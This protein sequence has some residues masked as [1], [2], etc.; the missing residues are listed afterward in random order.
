MPSSEWWVV[1][2]RKAAR[3]R[4][5][6]GQRA[7]SAA[8]WQRVAAGWGG[9]EGGGVG[10]WQH[11][12]TDAGGDHICG[13]SGGPGREVL[14]SGMSNKFIF[15]YRFWHLLTVFWPT[16]TQPKPDAQA[17]ISGHPTFKMFLFTRSIVLKGRF[18]KIQI[19]IKLEPYTEKTFVWAVR[20]WIGL[21][22]LHHN[23]RFYSCRLVQVL[24]FMKL[25]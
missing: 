16:L 1:A 13:G 4:V 5:E 24:L 7:S 21:L 3:W 22:D 10:G 17:S 9:V 23:V 20:A 25:W 14:H 18:L 6:G 2:G 8:R 12:I 15:F 19:K 11:F